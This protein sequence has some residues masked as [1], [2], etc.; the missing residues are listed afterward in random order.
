LALAK[1]RRTR[2]FES[3]YIFRFSVNIDI[4]NHSDGSVAHGRRSPAW[5]KP[6][7]LWLIITFAFGWL[8][9]GERDAAAQSAGQLNL[10]AAAPPG[11]TGWWAGNGSAKDLARNNDGILLRGAGFADGK[12]QKGF[13]LDGLD[14]CVRIPFSPNTASLK[15]SVELWVKPTAQVQDRENQDLIFGQAF[16]SPQLAVRPGSTGLHVRWQ[17]FVNPFSFPAAESVRQIP[18]NEWSHLAG[19]WDGTSLKLYINGVLEAQNSPHERPTPSTCDFFIG[20]FLNACG[21]TGQFFQGLIDEVSLYDRGLS[22]S[23]IRTIFSAGEAGKCPRPDPCAAPPSGLIASWTGNGHASDDQGRFV[24]VLTNGAGFVA[25]KAGQGF[26]FDGNAAGVV[27][28]NAP[29]LNFSQ[30]ADLSIETWIHAESG[31]RDYIMVIV[32]KRISPEVSSAVGYALSLWEGR[33]SFQLADAPLRITNFSNYHASRDLRDGL[34]HHVAVTVDR[35]NPAGGKMYVDGKEVLTFNPTTRGG[36]LS[37][38]G[39]LRIGHIADPNFKAFFKGVIDELGLYS[40]ALSA[41]E[42]EAIFNAGALGKC[43]PRLA[44]HDGIP[45]SWRERFFGVQFAVDDRAMAVADPDQ[46]GAINYQEF[47]AGTNPLDSKSVHRVPLFINTFAGSVKGRDD[48][49]LASATFTYPA[50]FARDAQGRLYVTEPYFPTFD[51]AGFGGQSIRLIDTNGIVSTWTGSAEPGLVEGPRTEARYRGPNFLVFDSF[52]NAFITDRYNHRIRKLDTNGIVS[53]FAGSTRGFSEGAGAN[54]QFRSPIGITIDP[55]NNLYVADWENYRIRKITPDGTVSTYA[56]SVAGNQNGPRLTATINGPVHIARTKDG[57]FYVADWGNGQIRKIAPDGIVSTF[58][59]GLPYVEAVEVDDQGDVYVVASQLNAII[60]FSP[61]GRE[62]W[63]LAPPRGT[64]D[65]PVSTAKIT[66]FNAPLLF[67]NG[68]ILVAEDSAHRLRLIKVGPPPLLEVRPPP[69][70]FTNSIVLGMSTVVKDGVIRYTLDESTPVSQWKLFTQGVALTNTATVLAQ[71][72]VNDLPVSEIV[73]QNYRLAGSRRTEFVLRDLP[74][75]YTPASSLTVYLKATPPSDAAVYAVEDS[76]PSGWTIGQISAGGSYDSSKGKVKFGPFFDALPRTLSYEVKPPLGAA[77]RE[78]F[79][80]FASVDGESGIVGGDLEI[81]LA[82]L[83]PADR[84]PDD[85]RVSIDE[86]TAYGLA[87]RKGLRWPVDPNP[88]PIDYVTRAA[89]LWK[90]GEAYVF[91]PAFTNAPVWWTAPSN[92]GSTL[93]PKMYSLSENPAA[94][95]ESRMSDSFVPNE[96]FLVEITA[97]PATRTAAYAVQD[98]IPAGWTIEQVGQSGD[99]DPGTRQIKWGPY[100]DS[101]PRTFSYQASPSASTGRTV[102]FEGSASFDGVSIPISGSRQ[103]RASIR[104]SSVERLPGGQIQLKLLGARE[105]QYVIESS[106]DLIR[107]T[108]LTVV[109]NIDGILQFSDRSDAD[110]PQRF[111]RVAGQ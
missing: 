97:R 92:V 58:A 44:M 66:H 16:G 6:V 50:G 27:I 10:C 29:G 24:G 82:R 101:N 12:V 80:G 81:E 68:D 35:D 77:G 41:A 15:F 76:P 20:G 59:S 102:N 96:P 71:V 45:A 70:V 32:D 51:V 7:S 60:K 28:P 78:S 98:Q 55:E 53:T 106:T 93:E 63:R 88:I 57:I 9:I 69:G 91:N 13:L 18:V 47:L 79:G 67:P 74:S 3:C 105:A 43:R 1:E 95:A 85:F 26:R 84:A 73:R 14:D 49:P 104:L 19:T 72:F 22:E 99:F 38:S 34:F 33:L 65:G 64:E 17:F 40:R 37:N 48:G 36:D 25:G 46:D 83:H 90:N 110:Q 2:W 75:F 86:V 30:G 108:P 87:W 89:A 23:E 62:I 94:R 111:Y 31:A 52:G 5:L 109:P 21:Y 100:F 107:W 42:I 103:A 4:L 56:G 54:A 8:G 11:L 61:D 39:P